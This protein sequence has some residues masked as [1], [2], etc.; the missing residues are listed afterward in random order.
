MAGSGELSVLGFSESLWDI[1]DRFLPVRMQDSFVY[2]PA[3][4]LASIRS[5]RSLFPPPGTAH[6]RSPP[7][8]EAAR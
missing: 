3:E 2:R 6:P 8:F 4:A 5:A 1:T 7:H